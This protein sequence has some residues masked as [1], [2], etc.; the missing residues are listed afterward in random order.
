[1]SKTKRLG[2]LPLRA[3]TPS[4]H[5]AADAELGGRYNDLL[6]S[7]LRLSLTRL[8]QQSFATTSNATLNP[9]NGSF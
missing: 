5:Y 4:E 6:M 9:R 1:M 2:Y 7:E 3:I 8:R